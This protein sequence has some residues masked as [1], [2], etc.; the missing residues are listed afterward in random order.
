MVCSA[1]TVLKW[2]AIYQILQ[3]VKNIC[4]AK[5]SQ[6]YF[7][8]VIQAFLAHTVIFF[9]FD[10]VRTKISHWTRGPKGV[11]HTRVELKQPGHNPVH[12]L[13]AEISVF[14]LFSTSSCSHHKHSLQNSHS[15][16]FSSLLSRF[17][18]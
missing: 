11:T 9:F 14:G 5:T 12:S 13:C 4:L 8:F 6:N 18:F 3:P 2:F 16:I 15:D 7:I 17:L 10:S 1:G